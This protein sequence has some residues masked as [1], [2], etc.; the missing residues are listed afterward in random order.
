[1]RTEEQRR[2]RIVV[3][4]AWQK[5]NPEKVRT[6]HKAWTRANPEKVRASKLRCSYG[7]T[8]ADFDR[9]FASQNGACAICQLPLTKGAAVDHD[10][11]TGHVRGLLHGACNSALGRFR[12][13]PATLRYAAQYLED[14]FVQSFSNNVATISVAA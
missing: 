6:A 13:S 11:E 10:H 7:L 9:L 4:R 5:A 14:A 12:D 1:V 2:A 8:P 3:S